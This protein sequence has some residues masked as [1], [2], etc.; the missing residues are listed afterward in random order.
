MVEP[1]VDLPHTVLVPTLGGQ[2][3]SGL[4]GLSITDGERVAVDRVVSGAPDLYDGEA[5]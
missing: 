4:D 3:V 2:E 5:P 1:L